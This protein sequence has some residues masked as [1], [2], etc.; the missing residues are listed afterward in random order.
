MI[1][2]EWD[3]VEA[4]ELG[5]LEP[6]PAS[7]RAGRIT[8]IKA[9]SRVVGP[10]D[11]FVALNTGVEYVADAAAR[12][13][14]TLVPRDQEAALAALAS[15]VRSKSDARVVAVVGST[16]KTSTKDILGALCGA[17]MPTIWAA[18]S[19][20]N[21][22]GLPLTVCRL[23]PET[24]MLVTEMGMRGLGQ[25]AELCAIARPD[26]VVVSS[27]G[28]EHLELVGTVERVA[29]GERRGDRR[30]AARRHRRRPRRRARARAAP[31]P[32]RHRDPPLRPGTAFAATATSGRSRS[33]G[34]ELTL[35]LPFTARH[36]AENTLAALTAYEA[37][38]LPLEQRPGGCG[39]DHALALA[40]RGVAAARRR[41]RRQR[42]LQ[43]Q[44]D[45]D[46]GR[47]RSTSS[48]AP[49]AGVGSRSWARWPSSATRRP[50][51]HEEVG[52]LLDE[53]GIELVDRGRRGRPSVPGR[54]RR[55]ADAP[56][57]SR[58][59][60]IRRRR[61]PCSSRATRS[62]SRPRARWGSKASRRRS[63]NGQEHGP[64]P[65]RRPRRD[66]DRHR[67]RPHLHRVAAPRRRRPA[68]PRGGPGPPHR[69]A[70][71]ADDGRP[72][73]PRHRG[74][75]V[76]R[77]LEVHAARPGAAVPH[78]RL[79][80]DRLHRRLPEGAQAPLARPLGALEDARPGADHDRRRLGRDAG[81]LPRHRDLLPDRRR[82][83]RP[84]L[85]LL[86]VPLH[87]DRGHGERRQPHRR[88]RRAR[89]GHVRDLAAHLPRDRG[90]LVDPL[91]RPSATAATTTS[92]SRSSRRR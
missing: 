6:P 57:D 22:I 12:G 89:G 17:V 29:R 39:R 80:R 87:R 21:E 25:I 20:N 58:R 13:A 56:L 71:D 73:D 61:G 47:A 92:T 46:A 62:S 23:E 41:H 64:S 4:L 90:D 14:A 85:V 55:R 34:G 11:L 69:Q 33:R 18:E 19:Q 75:A 37:L 43:R 9:D 50:R 67:D 52:A 10:G 30:P 77:A 48:R 54:R 1:P 70:G 53:L 35:T 5:T 82:Q 81:R 36:M 76:P 3:E 74:G 91:G 15:L 60:G 83:H 68:D 38:G 72:A 42:R 40:R 24:E 63:R 49:A 27:I 59:G 16:G 7:A 31:P 86:P 84:R 88:H 66:G 2:V 78:R 26:V 44:P 79:R 28:P 51:Y 45:V 32:H 65:D 8:G